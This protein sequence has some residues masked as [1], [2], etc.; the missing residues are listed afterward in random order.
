MSIR[1][2][3]LHPALWFIVTTIVIISGAVSMWDR[4]QHKFVVAGDYQLTKE[5]IKLNQPEPEW[6][7]TN[8]RQ[9][10]LDHL[11]Q[12][13]VLDSNVVV[14]TAD[15]I[16]SIGWV[17][18]VQRVEKS[19]NGL[20][21]DVV[22]REPVA[23]VKINDRQLLPV[24]RNGVIMD[25]QLFDKDHVSKFLRISIY[26]P[27]PSESPLLT[28]HQWPDSR[29]R[30]AAAISSV[31]SEHWQSQQLYRV[32]TFQLPGDRAKPEPFELWTQGH[33]QPG[34]VSQTPYAAKIRWGSSPGAEL[35]DEAD[36]QTKIRAINQFIEKFGPLAK[37][38]PPGKVLDVRTGRP[39]LTSKMRTANQEKISRSLTR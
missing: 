23:M 30:G 18:K 32:V 28:W 19:K 5:K 34:D 31:L 36:A 29:V 21:I 22:Y 24:D 7:N 13:T 9:V 37:S 17:E 8:I 10:L 16:R 6:T 39:I 4:Y 38:I 2:L 14:N 27:V 20:D 33:V 12:P 26:R 15:L 11:Q 35:I 25:G 3:A 1:S